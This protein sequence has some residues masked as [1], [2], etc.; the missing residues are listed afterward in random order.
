MLR[1]LIAALVG[2]SVLI[3]VPRAA[4][5]AALPA[6]CSAGRVSLTFDDG[7]SS[8]VT[9]RLV[10]I[11]K[12]ANVP[13]TF[14]MV[15]ERV[16]SAPR[17]A[18]LVAR[19]G[20]LVANHTYHHVNLTRQTRTAIRAT[21]RATDRR[22]RSLGIQPTS[23]MRP[24]YGAINDRVREAVRSAGLTPV[25]WDVDPRDWESGTSTATIASRILAQLR[26]HGSNIVLQHDGVGNSPASI[27][28]V[29]RVV[30]EARRRGYC[31]VALDDAGRPGF[32][33]PRASLS[34]ADSAEGGSATAVVKLD[35]PTARPTTVRLDTVA[36]TARPGTDFTARHAL[37]RFPAGAIRRQV[38]I[39]VLRDGLDEPTER[40]AVLL[41]RPSGLTL[42]TARGVVVVADRDP[43]P[44]VRAM[45]LDVV[46]P[47]TGPVTVDVRLRLSRVSGRTIRLRVITL[48]GEA[49]P[50]DYE[51]LD[52]T[53]TIRP[54]RMSATVPVT[55]NADSEDEAAETFVVRIVTAT[56]ARVAK[57]DAI[58]TITP[59][60]VA[61]TSR[62]GTIAGPTD[63][64]TLAP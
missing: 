61:P 10:R 59:P 2:A 63:A 30:R 36:G 13:A 8:T 19:S 23:L 37:V 58:I 15:G 35:R 20:F 5:S 54:G 41:S 9:P 31:F 27:A 14:F 50:G 51:P 47:A 48:P 25:L 42:G 38:S 7:P 49:V 1:F 55:V 24:P 22:L 18:R 21:L 39:P 34:V 4:D 12:R 40:F 29:P 32:P 64:P 46:E 45:D 56:H 52:V 33:V 57:R 16:A 6:A 60:P 26:P 43:A 11:L 62:A 44:A 28:A 17:V 3:A 53:V